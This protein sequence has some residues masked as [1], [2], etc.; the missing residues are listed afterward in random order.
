MP[1]EPTDLD[2]DASGKADGVAL[3][4]SGRGYRAMMFHVGAIC[5]LNEVRLLKKLSRISSV[6]GG[7]VTAGFLSP[8]WD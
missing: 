7:S 6:S 3:S 5:R 2:S 1:I 8:V 4:L